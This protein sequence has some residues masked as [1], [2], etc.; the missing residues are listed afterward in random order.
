MQSLL[1][2]FKSRKKSLNFL[3]R[4]SK[5]KFSQKAFHRFRV[6]VKKMNTLLLII[7]ATD[8]NFDRKALKK[9][10]LKLF[11]KAGEIRELQIEKDLLSEDKVLDQ[12]PFL[13][14]DLGK[15]IQQKRNEFFKIRTYSS[16]K[17]I[18]KKFKLIK[19][20]LKKIQPSE[21]SYFLEGQ[22]EDI[23]HLVSDGIDFSNAHLLR[24]KLKTYQYALEILGKNTLPI[25][26]AEVEELS[27][28]LGAWHDRDVFLQRVKNQNLSEKIAESERE[29]FNRF[30]A[31]MTK[32]S[33][34]YLQDIQ[35]KLALLQ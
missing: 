28:L 29:I 11:R 3:L 15:E 6:E 18:R 4:Y 5:R 23:L 21:F 14:K 1:K 16:S 31:Q 26:F 22:W 8:Q 17:K 7:Q 27:K 32:E 34:N 19:K 33:D 35:T 10:L 12:L 13:K 2:Y 25:H 24:K 20:D 9:P 30:I